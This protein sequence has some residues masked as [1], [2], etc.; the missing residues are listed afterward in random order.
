MKARIE[1]NALSKSA[2]RNSGIST[3]DDDDSEEDVVTKVKEDITQA[4]HYGVNLKFVKSIKP[5]TTG[6]CE[7]KLES[8]EVL[9]LSRRYRDELKANL[10]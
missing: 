1:I 7:I 6:D 5:L 9:S 10:I 8:G 2:L 4:V 3:D